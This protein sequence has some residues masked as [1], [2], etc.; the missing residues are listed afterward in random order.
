MKEAKKIRRA[1]VAIP[2][3]PVPEELGSEAYRAID[4]MREALTA[5]MSAG[6]SPTALSLALYDWWAH[7][8]AAPG[9][10]L[11]LADQA[12]RTSARL[13]SHI[14]AIA[15]DPQIV[16]TGADVADRATTRIITAAASLQLI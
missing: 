4:R 15:A 10:R 16:V 13:L 8:A 6:L 14:A 5:R 3:V 1:S 12:G 9:K 11:E 7:L 2:P